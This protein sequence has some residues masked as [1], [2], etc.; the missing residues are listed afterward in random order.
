MAAPPHLLFFLLVFSASIAAG[1]IGSLVGLGGGVFVVPL[2]TLVFGL[3]LQE[4]IGASIISVIATS[5]GAAAAYVRDR[6]TN[7]RVGMFLEIATTLGAITGAF[8]TAIAP[9]G[10][11]FLI[12]GLVLAVSAAP[13][14]MRFGEEL[15]QGV[16]NDRWADKLGLASSYRDERLGR[17]VAYQVERVPLGVVLMYIAGTIS[18]L[19]GIGS[20][21]FKVLAMDTAMRLPIK[22]SSATSNFMIGVTAAA[23]AGI[24]FWRGDVLAVVAAPVALG[25]LVGATLGAKMLVRFRNTT[26]RLIFLPVLAIVALEMLLRG[27][28]IV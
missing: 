13:L 2:L 23:S 22:V 3:P 28:G 26:V 4:A 15:P 14:I 10:L 21:T 17:E 27:F 24:Y 9:T 19:L 5:S 25:V 20:G 6:I 11:L 12:F 16:H 7:L 18:G 1:L 8:L